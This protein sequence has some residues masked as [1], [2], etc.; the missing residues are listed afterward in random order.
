MSF[1][2]VPGDPR[3]TVI[4]HVPHSSR[5]IPVPVWAEIILDDD[6][7]DRELDAMTDA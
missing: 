5:E 6:E 2:I 7:L 3:S 4:I 1:Q